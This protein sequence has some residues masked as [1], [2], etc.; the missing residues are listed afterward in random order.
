MNIDEIEKI[1]NDIDNYSDEEILEIY[2]KIYNTLYDNCCFMEAE[3]FI[4][5]LIKKIKDFN[6]KLELIKEYFPNLV[7]NSLELL[8]RSIDSLSLYDKKK[9]FKDLYAEYKFVEVDKLLNIPT[10]LKL[11]V[12][13][14]YTDLSINVIQSL[15]EN[16]TLTVLMQALEINEEICD[17]II[18]KTVFF[19]SKEYDK[20]VFTTEKQFEYWPELSSAI[21]KNNI[22]NLNVLKAFYYI[23]LVL[24]AK[25]NEETALQINVGVDYFDNNVDG[26]KYLLSIWSECEEIF[27]KI[28]NK[29]NTIIRDY[30]SKMAKPIKANIQ[31]TFDENYSFKLDTPEDFYKFIYNIQVRDYLKDLFHNPFLEEYNKIEDLSEDE[32]YEMFLN[33]PNKE[34][35]MYE[36]RFTSINFTYMNWYEENKGRI[37]FRLFNNIMDFETILSNITLVGRL[38]YVSKEL[39]NG[40]IELL[41]KYYMLLKKDILEEEKLDLLLNLLFNDNE[42]EIF[43]RRWDSVKNNNVYNKYY[44]GD[45]TFEPINNEIKSK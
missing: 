8:L 28:S 31:K 11:G 43:K 27:Y 33:L 14:E 10:N 15:F 2:K 7:S 6:I 19:A 21:F 16:G 23:M 18:N 4:V 45:K 9:I 32:K 36:T 1:I 13:L 41:K 3:E 38:M 35:K 29:E 22:N 44:T 26:L 5:I 20:W 34:E 40:N 17:E 42:K 24:K 37:E 12:E 25:V 30:A 39:A